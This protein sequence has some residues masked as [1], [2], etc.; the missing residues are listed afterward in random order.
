[1]LKCHLEEKHE[2]V[3]AKVQKSKQARLGS[4]EAGTK[5]G[6]HRITG[7]ISESL[8]EFS[9]PALLS[10]LHSWKGTTLLPNCRLYYSERRGSNWRQFTLI[11]SPHYRLG[12]GAQWLVIGGRFFLMRLT[13]HSPGSSV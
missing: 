10:S 2:L 9:S 6:R 7:C 8:S 4:Q 12:Y 13:A 1:M 5:G 3:M 11:R